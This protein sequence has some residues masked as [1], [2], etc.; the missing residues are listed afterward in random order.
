MEAKYVVEEIHNILGKAIKL[1]EFTKLPLF[2]IMCGHT[3]YTLEQ[4]D[5][6]NKGLELIR[7][8]WNQ[9]IE[10]YPNSIHSQYPFIIE[11]K[12]IIITSK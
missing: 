2:T 9:V 10:K 11:I 8:G 4:D 12:S 6:R 7:L 5:F 1:A 3:Y